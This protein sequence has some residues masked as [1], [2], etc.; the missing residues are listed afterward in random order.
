MGGREGGGVGDDLKM[1]GVKS[2][3]RILLRG[4]ICMYIVR[5]YSPSFACPLPLI[6]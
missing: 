6:A 5:K 2:P 3:Q 1:S 4:L